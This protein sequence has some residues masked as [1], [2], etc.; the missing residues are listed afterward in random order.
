[1]ATKTHPLFS[2]FSSG[3]I[4]PKIDA[5]IDLAQYFN[6]AQEIRNWICVPQGGVKTRGGFH[7]VNE[8]KDSGIAR[9]IPFCFS[10]LQNYMLLF[11]EEYIW[12]F[13]D[14]GF[15]TSG[16]F[17]DILNPEIKLSIQWPS[18]SFPID[19]FRVTTND[20]F[21]SK[22]S[23]NAPVY[24]QYGGTR[25]I[26]RTIPS[27]IPYKIETPYR[28]EDDLWSIRYAQDD[29]NLF[30]VHPFYPPMVLQKGIG[31]TSFTLNEM[32][33]IDGPYEDEVLTPTIT[34]SDT[35][36]DI[37]LTA[38]DNLFLPG[39]VGALWR[40]NHT[41]VWSYVKI[42]GYT[43]STLVNATVMSA[44]TVDAATTSHREGAWS[45][46]NGWPR[47]ICFHEGRMLFASNYERP[48]TVW[49]SKTANYTDFTPG[50]LDND[51]YTFTPADLNIIRW[52]LPG[53]QLSIGALN[54]E[55]TAVGPSDG[56]ITAADPPTI[57]SA[58]THGSSNLIAPVRV[59]KAILFLQRAARKIREFVYSYADDTYGAPDVT[60]ASEHLF[61]S[62]IVDLV[63][64]QEPD[65]ILWAIRNDVLGTLLACTYDRYMDPTKGG[66]VAWSRHYTDGRFESIGTIP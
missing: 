48:Q 3:E 20:V 15:I 26:G 45:D 10:E 7:F 28:V 14:K 39:H 25:L 21:M 34:P 18:S 51:A 37:T 30:L 36:G 54:V 13:M 61:T 8:T 5:R 52:I 4:S 63:Y 6:G 35:T 2:N 44:V 58:T 9:L 65:S 27:N 38:S 23:W 50:I 40:L 62:D 33:F 32:E 66:I 47:Q 60:I 1:M 43:S 17:P 56:P 31:H 41:A 59:G 11:G 53:R 12:F 49:G 55:A 57:K 64:Q 46:V 29:E 16:L 42:T 24:S 19:E 22:T